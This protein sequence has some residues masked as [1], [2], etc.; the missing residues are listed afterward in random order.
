MD[1]LIFPNA[2]KKSKGIA[3]DFS[4]YLRIAKN[5]I[6]HSCKNINNY[7]IGLNLI[8]EYFFL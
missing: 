2:I 3:I 1:K 7:Y 8:F 4:Y 6:Y 5:K